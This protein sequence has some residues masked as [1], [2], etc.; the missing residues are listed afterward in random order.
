MARSTSNGYNY[1][2]KGKPEEIDQSD[3]SVNNKSSRRKQSRVKPKSSNVATSRRP[4]PGTWPAGPSES[5]N[6]VLR[7][8]TVNPNVP[9]PTEQD[10]ALRR[11]SRSI[12]GFK[13][14][15]PGEPSDN[16]RGL[17]I[18]IYISS[19]AVNTIRSRAGDIGS[20][21]NGGHVTTAAED[22]LSSAGP[23]RTTSNRVR[24]G[25]NVRLH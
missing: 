2:N 22:S 3:Q 18:Y 16:R 13:R 20:D 4:H 11:S 15:C 23:S 5:N 19:L 17:G 7:R 21:R 9:F 24:P 12:R 10:L 1:R 6:R 14:R 8:G 25:W